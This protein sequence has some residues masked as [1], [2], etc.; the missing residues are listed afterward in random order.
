MHR[1]AL[2]H[3]VEWKE[4]L[5][6]KPMVVRGARQVGKSHLVRE[7]AKAAFASL[8]EVNFEQQPEAAALFGSRHPEKIVSE[9]GI[10]LGK[11]I[12]PGKT[13]VFL[14]EIQAVPDVLPAL[15]FFH[16]QM[17]RLH[18][19]AAGSLLDFALSDASGPVPVGRVEF[20]HLGPMQ[21][22]E[23][24][25]GVGDTRLCQFVQQY[26]L[27]EDIPGPIH[28]RLMARLRTFLAVGGMPEAV[29]HYCR[30][31][32]YLEADMIKRS[33]LATYQD[34]FA[35]YR[36]RADVER[37]RKVFRALPAL[38]GKRFRYA[39]VDREERS[40]ELARALDLLCLARVAYRVR[41]SFSNM[42]PLAAQAD[43]RRFKTL[44]LDVGL[45]SAALG[46]DIVGI[47]RNGPLAPA[48]SGGLAEQFVGQ[49]LLYS[50]PCWQE[51]ELHYWERE[52]R[53][54]SAEVDYVVSEGQ[55]V[56]PVEVKAGATGTLRSLHSFVAQKGSRL[57]VRLNALPPQ[58]VEVRAVVPGG[59]SVAFRLLSLPLY[60]VGQT[61]R[62][63]RAA[64]A[65][66]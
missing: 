55:T 54:S 27:N 23:F 37:I 25:L 42:A 49:H 4:R 41:H 5:S 34:D 38:V 8:A 62:L 17:P 6:R 59:A 10:W 40:R 33:I 51:P 2:Q 30:T 28:T 65:H 45:V 50:A 3:L 32:G 1:F 16:E 24:L 20:L 58:A 18:V 14:D 47:E 60:L 66:E 26:D 63:I 44:F 22:E 36:R 39:L 31:G 19:V 48:N 12:A 35:K 13:L 46:L 56:F 43:D 11:S 7:F 21:F 9:L 29:A 61:R 52:A 64:E 15:R 53:G 57:A